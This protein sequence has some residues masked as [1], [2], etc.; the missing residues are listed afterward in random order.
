MN[1]F[2]ENVETIMNL[3]PFSDI[4]DC[5][6]NPCQYNGECVDGIANYTCDCVT[7]VHG[8]NCEIS[9]YKL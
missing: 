7:G 8:P 9:K 6:P 2:I 1:I 5:D 3:F 4:N